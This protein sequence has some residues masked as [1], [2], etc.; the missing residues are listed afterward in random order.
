MWKFEP[1]YAKAVDLGLTPMQSQE[2]FQAMEYIE[3]ALPDRQNGFIEIGSAKGGSFFC[4]ASLFNGH[5]VSIDLPEVI[6]V[7]STETVHR[8]ATWREHFG[9]RVSIIEENS[10]EV[11]TIHTIL[12]GVL[13]GTLLDFLFLDGDHDYAH[14][15]NDFHNYKKYIRPGGFIGFHDIY[16]PAHV[17][18][19]AKFFN[20]L[21][22][23][24][25][26]TNPH[27]NGI[28]QSGWAGIGIFHV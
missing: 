20:E 13:Q 14:T 26:T 12:D 8:N 10:M 4:W 19:C 21:S 2:I 3:K 9:D 17:D 1:V 25:Y 18:G 7:S 23:L 22:G 28:N 15:Y 6:G 5:A 16:H 11:Q 24:K 27:I